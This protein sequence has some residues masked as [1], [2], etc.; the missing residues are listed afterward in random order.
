MGLTYAKHG[1]I[2]AET[3]DKDSKRL[4]E[5]IDDPLGLEKLVNRIDKLKPP[6]PRI[7]SSPGTKRVCVIGVKHHASFILYEC[8]FKKEGLGALSQEE[9]S[10][11]SAEKGVKLRGHL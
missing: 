4:Q 11:E 2:A 10:K 9:G 7:Q 5:H 8:H 6:K 3:A 1:S